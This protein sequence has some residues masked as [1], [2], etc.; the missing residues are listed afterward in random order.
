M[1]ASNGRLELALRWAKFYHQIQVIYFCFAMKRKLVFILLHICVFHHS[2]QRQKWDIKVHIFWDDHKILRNLH[3]RFDCYYIGKNYRGD[4]AKFYGLLR[5]YEL[6]KGRP[7]TCP[8]I[9]DWCNFEDINFH[10]WK[11]KAK[12]NHFPT[13]KLPL[14]PQVPK[15]QLNPLI[16]TLTIIP[17]VIPH[18]LFLL[19]RCFNR[20]L[21]WRRFDSL[22]LN[23][24]FFSTFYV[25]SCLLGG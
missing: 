22:P 24:V 5:I 3:R 4:F 14:L 6:Y 13:E 21:E 2:M 15:L 1:K 25:I 10:F 8:D 23:F 20:C 17:R 11:G 7:H 19:S 16:V 18:L 12:M 9:I